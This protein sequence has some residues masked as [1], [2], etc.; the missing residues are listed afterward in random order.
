MK[1]IWINRQSTLVYTPVERQEF[2]ARKVTVTDEQ[3]A[4]IDEIM[5]NYKALSKWAADSYAGLN[6]RN[7]DKMP[8]FP[9][10]LDSGKDQQKAKP[11][12]KGGAKKRVRDGSSGD[13][14][15]AGG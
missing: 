15:V 3:K 12:K 1:D 5:A 9:E 10:E 8:T 6:T 13:A 4:V 14:K 7:E 11:S 2:Y